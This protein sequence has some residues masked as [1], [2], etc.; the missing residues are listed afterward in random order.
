[1][2]VIEIT[3]DKDSKG[4]LAATSEVDMA[5]AEFFFGEGLAFLKVESKPFYNFLEKH[6]QFS[7]DWDVKYIPPC[8]KTLA[9][10]TLNKVQQLAVAE[11][12]RLFKDSNSVLLVDGWRN[13]A[14]NKKLFV[15]TLKNI[16]VDQVFLSAID[17]SIEAESGE[18]L[19]EHI[20]VATTKAKDVYN[21]NVFAVVSD[22]ASSIQSGCR[23]ARNSDGEPLWVS[24]CSSHSA[25][26]IFNQLTNRDPHFFQNVKRIIKQYREPKCEALLL[27]L[28][29]KRMIPYPETRFCYIRDS[30]MSIWINLKILK[31]LCIVPDLQI[32]EDVQ[33]HIRSRQFKNK[34]KDY[35]NK[36]TPICKLINRWQNPKCNVADSTENWWELWQNIDESMKGIILDR[37]VKAV[38]PVGYAANILHHKYQGQRLQPHPDDTDQVRILKAIGHNFIKRETIT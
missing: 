21:T 28:K 32:Y 11:R 31:D 20:N 35:I 9:G 6:R 38:F 16:R 29:G 7:R 18:N 37:I 12:I 25:D 4:F 36:F 33:R 14:A 27:R 8:R 17:M 34:L 3:S 1:M 5:L 26:L 22:N 30:M 15:C 13:K 23:Q 24:T 10:A 2:K 19:A